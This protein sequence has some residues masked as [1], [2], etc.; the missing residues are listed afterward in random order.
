MKEGAAKIESKKDTRESIFSVSQ[1]AWKFSTASLN[2]ISLCINR[3][4]LMVNFEA[5]KLH[6]RNRYVAFLNRSCH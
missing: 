4:C 5:Q 2:G 3:M 6:Q 1:Y